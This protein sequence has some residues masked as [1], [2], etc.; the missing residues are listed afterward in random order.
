MRVN[1]RG[2]NP[3]TRHSAIMNYVS[4]SPMDIVDIREIRDSKR[5]LGASQIVETNPA[6]GPPPDIRVVPAD[7]EEYEMAGRPLPVEGDSR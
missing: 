5:R 7:M 6:V 1:I 3:H 4:I 2:D